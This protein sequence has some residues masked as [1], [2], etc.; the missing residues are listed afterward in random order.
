LRASTQKT[1]MYAYYWK[2]QSVQLCQGANWSHSPGVMSSLPGSEVS[3]KTLVPSFPKQPSKMIPYDSAVGCSCSQQSLL[4]LSL[5]FSLLRFWTNSQ[6]DNI[7]TTSPLCCI[8][9]KMSTAFCH[10]PAWPYAPI[11]ACCTTWEDTLVV[12]LKLNRRYIIL[13]LVFI[14]KC[15]S[16]HHWN[17]KATILGFL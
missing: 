1:S 4:D 5:S 3:R 10:C 11:K 17:L 7:S 2:Y 9:R 15:P 16:Q 13:S 6:E 14:S 8:M 12:S